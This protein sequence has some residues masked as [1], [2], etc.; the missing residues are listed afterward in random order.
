MTKQSCLDC[1][2]FGTSGFPADPK[3]HRWRHSFKQARVAGGPE[4]HGGAVRTE[5][6]A[7]SRLWPVSPGAVKGSRARMVRRRTLKRQDDAR[8]PGKLRTQEV[9]RLA[10]A[11][12]KA[13]SKAKKLPDGDPRAL[14]L[15]AQAATHARLIRTNGSLAPDARN[16]AARTRQPSA[17]IRQSLADVE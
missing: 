4:S 1:G 15:L 10:E 7:G 12:R 6:S 9:L 16:S 8:D 11:M 2:W 3:C 5:A 17:K 14:R 13:V